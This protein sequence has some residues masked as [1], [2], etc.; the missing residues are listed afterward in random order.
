MHQS[1]CQRRSGGFTLV[2]ALVAVGLTTILMWGLLQLYAS[3][4]RFSSTVTMEAALCSAGRAVLERMV[5]ELS[6]ATVRETYD[7]Q[8]TG[9]DLGSV[10]FHAPVGDDGEIVH[11]D[12]YIWDDDGKNVLMRRE[13]ST[14]A[15]FGLNVENFKVTCIDADGTAFSS[16]KSFP[17]ELPMAVSL[18]ILLSDRNHRATIALSSSAFLPGSGL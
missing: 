8:I 11:I 5:R 9:G 15:S 13:G 14:S 17:D 3:A 12:Y 16:S 6:S 4:R 2:E 7:L 18:E 1:R 10:S